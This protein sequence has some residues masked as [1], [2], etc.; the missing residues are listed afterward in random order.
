MI[1]WRG[2]API[3]RRCVRR[4]PS[5]QLSLREGL[6]WQ[7][8]L[9]ELLPGRHRRA[10]GAGARL[11]SSCVGSSGCRSR[12]RPEVADEAARGDRRAVVVRAAVGLPEGGG[13][14]Q[15]GRPAPPRPRAGDGGR[16]AIRAT[17]ARGRDRAA[18]GA[19]DQ[20][21]AAPASRAQSAG[22]KT[23]PAAS[24]SLPTTVDLTGGRSPPI[25]IDRRASP[26][27]SRAH[28]RREGQ[29]GR[30]REGGR[31]GRG[32]RVAGARA[33]GPRS[34][35]PAR[36]KVGATQRR[37][38]LEAWRAEALASGQEV[39]RRARPRPRR[40]TPRRRGREADAR[41]A[42]ARRRTTR[43]AE[44]AGRPSGAR[45][46]GSSSAA[47]PFRARAST[48]STSSPT[49]ADL[50]DV[51]VP[52]PRLREGSGAR[53]SRRPA[54]VQL[55]AYPEERFD[56]TV[57]TSASRSIRSRAPSPRASGLANRDDLLRA[58]PLRHGPRRRPG[59]G[60]AER[61]RWS[62][63]AGAVDGRRQ[64]D[65]VFV[66]QPDGDFELHEVVVGDVGARQGARS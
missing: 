7:R 21:A 59:R 16:R 20:G 45:S 8:S 13:R 65:V 50:D 42:R 3:C 62:S 31:D 4:S 60:R 37:T 14:G 32:A 53:R 35:R 30:P 11:G 23:A 64:A 52:R 17:S 47:T 38:G 36:A 24:D 46:P 12:P 29:G 49:I 9:I 48:P 58:R 56:G 26:R 5:R 44:R 22:I 18:R 1:S 33:T 39:G 57:E 54:E 2:R 43:R 25:P 61:R 63:R 27:A 6:Q 51:L 55:N 66:R 40:S 15:G 34:P 10:A 41:R 28:R 19:A